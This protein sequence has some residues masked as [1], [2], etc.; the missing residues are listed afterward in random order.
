MRY[1]GGVQRILSYFGHRSR[2]QWILLGAAVL[3]LSASAT[4]LTFFLPLVLNELTTSQLAIGFAVG[5]EGFIA[6]TVPLLV[7]P[8]SDRT[9]NRFGRRIPYMLAATPLVFAGLLAV[10]LL[11]SYW[12]IVLAV[13]L[14]FTG[15]YAYY[16]AY[17]SLYPDT[18]PPDEYGR[19]WGYQSVFQGFGVAIALLGGGALLTVNLG[20]SFIAT[21]F[22]FVLI[23]GLTATGIREQKRRT[24]AEASRLRAALPNFLKRVIADRN[25]RLF[26]VSH[27]CWEFT[28]AAIR[29]FVLLYLLK[30]LG[31]E[32]GALL[33]ILV[34]VIVTYLIASV[35]SG[36][37]ADAYDPR[38][39][40]ASVVVLFAAGML[41][42]GLTTD[43]LVLRLVLP[44]GMFAGAAVLMLSYPI[45]LRV[46]PKDR[47]GEYT[48]YYQF[49]RGLALLFG[50]S[51]TGFLIDSFGHHFP[52]TEGYQVLWLTTATVTFLS[53]PFFLALTGGSRA[54]P[55]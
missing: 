11:P 3:G 6:L 54:R 41:V 18:L 42:T 8:A 10:A 30:G 40:T 5:V 7:G 12:L 35:V 25:L 17:Q 15:Y 2:R 45:L 37:I 52:E 55:S 28:L 20:A 23:A 34:V 26:L 27:F 46:T 29:A 19:A 31:M 49:N 36:H 1:D 4:V 21:A 47:R 51:L 33:V 16:T 39:Y 9:W 13:M 24:T 32:S 22:F 43:Q 38:R 14:F 48:G 53:L 50:T 44:F